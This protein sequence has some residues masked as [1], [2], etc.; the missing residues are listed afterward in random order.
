MTFKVT[1]KSGKTMDVEALSTTDAKDT[2]SF[3]RMT[4]GEPVKAEPKAPKGK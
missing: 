4:Y 1:F 2:A 3:F